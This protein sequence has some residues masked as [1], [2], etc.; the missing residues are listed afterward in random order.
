MYFFCYFQWD[1]FT[2]SV[3]MTVATLEAINLQNL[4]TSQLGEFIS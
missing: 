3:L 4:E 2:L 1:Y